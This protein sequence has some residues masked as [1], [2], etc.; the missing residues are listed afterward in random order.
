M[1]GTGRSGGG[2]GGNEATEAGEG[3]TVMSR[4]VPLG[5]RFAQR[6]GEMDL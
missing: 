3:E 5:G 6:P 2:D 4:M 1:V